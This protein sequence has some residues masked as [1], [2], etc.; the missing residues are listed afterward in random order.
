MIVPDPRKKI[1]TILMARMNK[2]G[3]ETASNMLPEEDVDADG[4]GLKAAAEDIIRAMDSKSAMALA[5]AM[6]SFFMMCD[7]MPHAEGGE[8]Q[9]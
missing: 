4:E 5:D 8:E 6:K 9:E 2:D 3:K 7:A 1:A